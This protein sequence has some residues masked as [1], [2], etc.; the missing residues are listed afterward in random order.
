M[1]GI[2]VCDTQAVPQHQP[3][4]AIGV[5]CMGLAQTVAQALSAYQR[6]EMDEAERL[7]RLVLDVDPNHFDALHI[8]GI[9]ALQT[10]RLSDALE[11]LTR[12]V[13]IN[14]NSAF[15]HGNRATVLFELERY[16]EA[17]T[18][19]DHALEISPCYVAGYYNRANALTNLKRFDEA[20]AGYDRALELLG[21]QAWML[22]TEAGHA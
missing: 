3:S 20:V 11:L 6:D 10:L 17:V 13:S 15:C 22:S 8:L 5:G 1:P 19:Y 12:A 9:V 7:C 14:P 4:R 21:V 2:S 18:A 16:E